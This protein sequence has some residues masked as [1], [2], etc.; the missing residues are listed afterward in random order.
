MKGV[1]Y[2]SSL[3]IAFAILKCN[4]FFFFADL[5][6]FLTAAYAEYDIMIW[7]ATRYL[8]LFSCVKILVLFREYNILYNP[9][10]DS[11]QP[12]HTYIMFFVIE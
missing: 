2:Y 5:H 9:C 4:V 6:E 3:F 1:L 10:C 8:P 12:G 11:L 7:S